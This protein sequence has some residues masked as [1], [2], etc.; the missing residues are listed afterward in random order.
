MSYGGFQ[1]E[2]YGRRKVGIVI[3]WGGGVANISPLVFDGFIRPR[4]VF[5]LSDGK[6]T[7]YVTIWN[8]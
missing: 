7:E 3:I 5:M 4:E 2:S 8:Q 6:T 1:H